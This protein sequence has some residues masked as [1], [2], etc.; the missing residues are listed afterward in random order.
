[1]SL[2]T[3]IR[4]ACLAVLAA[5]FAVPVLAADGSA[6]LPFRTYSVLDGLTQSNALDIKQDRSG[7]LWIA[8]ARGLNRYDGK[9]FK[10]YTIADGLPNN[11]LTS[12]HVSADNT[13]WVGDQKGTVSALRGARV[14]HEIAVVPDEDNPVIALESVGDESAGDVVLAVIEGMGIAEIVKVDDVYR[15]RH[16]AGNA[17]HGIT[18]IAVHGE[19]IWV[20]SATGLYRLERGE[21][22]ELAMIDE[23]IRTIHVDTAGELWVVDRSNNIGVF[24]DRVFDIR[25]TLESPDQLVGIAVD[26]KGLVSLST[27]DELLQFDSSGESPEEVAAT[28]KRYAGIDR[29]TSVFLDNEDSVWL[30]T[31]NGMARF[32]GDR[33]RHFRLRTGPDLVTVWTVGEDRYGRFWFGTQSK[34]IVREPDE[35][36]TIV[37]EDFGLPAAAVRDLISDG[38]GTV[39][40]GVTDHGLYAVNSETLR[41]KHV[42]GTDGMEILDIDIASDGAIWL[43][44]IGSGVYRYAPAT[45]TLTIFPTPEETSVYTL[46]TWPDG[47]V[48]YAADE[49]G[50]VHL[51]PDGA[52]RYTRRLITESASENK[53]LYNHI[54]VTGSDSAWVSTE[55]GGVLYYEDGTFRNYGLNTPLADQTVYLVEPLDNGSVV[56]GG[57]KGLYQFVPGEA[58]FAHFNPQRGFIGMETNVHASFRDS[59][60]GLWIGTVDGATRMDV[61]QA[62][63]H[64]VEPTPSIVRVE[65]VLDGRRILAGQ[66]Q[67][68]SDFGAQFEF[69]A[70]SLLAPSEMQYSYRLV[71]EEQVWGAPTTNRSVGYPR[72]PPGSYEFMVRARYSGGDWGSHIA[73][74]RFTVKPFFWQQPWFVLGVLAV[75]VL[76]IRQAINYRTRKIEWMNETLR[77]QVEER[78]RSIETA[79]QNLQISNERLFLE[80][81]ARTEIETRFRQAFENAPIGMGLLDAAGV[82][83]DAN[84]ALIRMFWPNRDGLPESKFVETV[85]Q[86]DRLQFV[87][88]YE[89]LVSAETEGLD[90]NL[91]CIGPNGEE[92]HAIIN[93]SAVRS[94]SGDFLYTVLQI[95]DMTES[96]KLTVQLEYQASYDEL[97]ELLNRR[98]FEEQLEKAWRNGVDAER[99]SYLMFMDLDQFKVVNDTSGHTAGDQLL[100][101]VSEILLDSVRANDIVGRLGGDEFGIIL[102]EC[103]TDVAQRI[104]ESIRGRVENFRFHWDTETYRIGVSIGGIPVAK[105]VGDINEIQQLAD[106]ACYAAKEAGRNRV[107]MVDGDAD[108]A[109][110]HRGEVR[111]VQRIREAMDKN[112]FAIYAQPIRPIAGPLDEPERLEILLRLR[113]P[114][115]RKL[116]PPGAF[117]PAAERY[118]LSVELDKWVVKSLLDTLFVHSAFRA[119]NRSYWI[120]LSGSSVG[121][122]RFAAFLKDAIARSPLPPG[123]INFEITE[124]AVIRSV[125]E[126]GKLMTALREMGCQ[127]ALDDF[128]SGLSSFGYLK[129]LPVDYIKIDG[130]F[131]RDLIHDNTDR[132]FVKSIIDIAETLNIKTIAEFVES[133]EILDVVAELGAGYAQGFAV[134]RPFE[135]APR[136][137][138]M[139]S[140]EVA[141]FQAKTG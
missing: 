47:S 115:S 76:T 105:G 15:S 103:P 110:L 45:G 54:R 46:D 61:F 74:H 81:E 65:T 59:S 13:I 78:T 141:V 113:D 92:L 39:W 16:V 23:R 75:L 133:N 53:R 71:G 50:I 18:G 72:I 134:G 83:F 21:H 17:S 19:N 79:R 99:Q 57:E 27:S 108:S 20:E 60:G 51:Q 114:A 4:L 128:G 112:R 10:H 131:I 34:L 97:T 25:L 31:D 9:A 62:M 118:G 86:R 48:W 26:R 37:G 120:N 121:D 56:V 117:L 126:A 68:P 107:H 136:F 127:F 33:F 52:G 69:A 64:V 109:R 80:V 43:S 102:W 124:T 58:E 28:L 8:T 40:V 41:A 122:K 111:W 73:S 116:I 130:M 32:L 7:Y 49:V 55:E 2:K 96:L 101:A 66:E 119:E 24:R 77:A 140:S 30:S 106:A 125:S 104:A 38:A 91:S 44:T 3:H 14:I 6:T 11:A 22:P 137:P 63:P 93:L 29:V 1:M 138:R 95:Q 85:S 5:V 12:I 98:A 82:L 100:R 139:A 129:K 67:E 89:K 94:D 132:I 84:P 88:K 90:V 135:L 123:T 87:A 70:I 42:P 35:T 36:L